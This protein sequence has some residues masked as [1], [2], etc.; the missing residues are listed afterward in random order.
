MY[1]VGMFRILLIA[2]L[3]LTAGCAGSRS[4]GAKPRIVSFKIANSQAA[5]KGEPRSV[6]KVAM[7]SGAGKFIV[8][9]GGPW[10][11][12]DKGVALKCFRNGTE[13]GVVTVSGERRGRFLTADIVSGE[14]LRGDEVFE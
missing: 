10:G 13:V 1:K 7:V 6:G 9:E 14:F 3:G 8:I 11:S 12:P 2:V 5:A 4:N